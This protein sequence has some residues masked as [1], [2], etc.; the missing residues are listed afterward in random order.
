MAGKGES[1]EE[2]DTFA[3]VGGSFLSWGF[4]AWTAAEIQ[5]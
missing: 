3:K 2:M 5:N 1:I 4:G